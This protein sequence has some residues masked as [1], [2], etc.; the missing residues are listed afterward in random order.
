MSTPRRQGKH[1]IVQKNP[2]P[3]EHRRKLFQTLKAAVEGASHLVK[4]PVRWDL[5]ADAAPYSADRLRLAVGDPVHLA[6]SIKILEQYSA[7]LATACREKTGAGRFL[8]GEALLLLDWFQ[9]M[10]APMHSTD[11]FR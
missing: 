11:R 2:G 3:D 4:A 1:P 5:R 10:E 8:G 6:D 9:G 7:S